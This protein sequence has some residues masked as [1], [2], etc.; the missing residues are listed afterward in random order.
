MAEE[1]VAEGA[2][3]GMN[4]VKLS[5]QLL[6]SGGAI[7]EIIAGGGEGEVTILTFEENRKLASLSLIHI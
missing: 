2:A 1:R 7:G 6:A 5:R 4:L 3:F